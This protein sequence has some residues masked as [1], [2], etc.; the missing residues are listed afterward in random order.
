M[1]WRFPDN[2]SYLGNQLIAL[3]L[4]FSCGV[5]ALVS[6]ALTAE[7]LSLLK[8]LTLGH[9]FFT[10]RVLGFLIMKI[11]AITAASQFSF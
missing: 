8:T 6:I 10:I 3:G 7:N 1:A 5:L 11:F 9:N 4:T 2:R